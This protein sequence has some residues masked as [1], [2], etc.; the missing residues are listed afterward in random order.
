MEIQSAAPSTKLAASGSE[1]HNGAR[2]DTASA[3]AARAALAGE[4]RQPCKLRMR[5]A[6]V[7]ADL[8]LKREIELLLPAAGPGASEVLRLLR[9]VLFPSGVPS[10]VGHVFS[11]GVPPATADVQ[12]SFSEPTVALTTMTA[13]HAGESVPFTAPSGEVAATSTASE[14]VGLSCT[15][16]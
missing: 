6:Q 14:L 7:K 12:L 3:A 2:P 8:I 15:I 11:M 5:V 16:G 1:A 13:L 10:A 4:S 9:P